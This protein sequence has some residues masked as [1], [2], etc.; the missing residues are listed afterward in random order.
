MNVF[1]IAIFL[2]TTIM[3]FSGCKKDDDA[4]TKGRKAAIEL[5]DCLE[6]A[7]T[8]SEIETC[9]GNFANKYVKY[10]DN[11]K[12]ENAAE[13]ELEKCSFEN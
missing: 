12:F 8:L 13:A 4:A 1:A 7:G 9:V 6:K 10:K 11:E 5:C 2:A 3:M